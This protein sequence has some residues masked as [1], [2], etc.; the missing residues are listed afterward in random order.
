M[1]SLKR[2][3]GARRTSG[4]FGYIDLDLDVGV[5]IE[6]DHEPGPDLFNPNL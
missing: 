4:I 1:R 3:R 2:M 6:I 5:K